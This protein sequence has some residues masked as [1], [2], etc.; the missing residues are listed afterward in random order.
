M[1]VVVMV[2]FNIILFGFADYIGATQHDGT[3]LY[4][5]F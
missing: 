2:V 1:V 4:V 3:N 5:G